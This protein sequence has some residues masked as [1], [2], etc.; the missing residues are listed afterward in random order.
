M[1]RVRVRLDTEQGAAEILADLV[2]PGLALHR[3]KAVRDG[4]AVTVP[5]WTL[6]HAVSGRAVA[7]DAEKRVLLALAVL[8]HD[9][10]DWTRPAEE[11]VAIDG[12]AAEVAA[13]L[14]DAR[15]MLAYATEEAR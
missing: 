9:L 15:E 3:S 6:T 8:I 11:L 10:V 7:R 1:A 4:Q 14:A 12:L 5:G 2:A 13:R